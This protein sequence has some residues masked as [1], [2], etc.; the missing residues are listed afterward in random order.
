M[1][2]LETDVDVARYLDRIGHRGPTDVSLATLSA[3]QRAHMTAVPFENLDVASGVEVRT[4]LDW[5]L[6]KI[7]D[8][9]RGGWC[10]EV[11]GAFGALLTAMG[12]EVQLLGAAVLLSGPNTL[13]DHLMLEVT[14]D[15]PWLVDVG[16]GEGFT[17]PLALNGASPQPGGDGIYQF[18]PSPQGTTLAKLDD[19]VPVAQYRFKRVAHALSEFD[20]A[21]HRL[22]TDPA[23]PFVQKPFATRLLDGGPERVTLLRNRLRHL[24]DGEW[25]EQPV[26]LDQWAATLERWFGIGDVPLPA[27]SSDP[28]HSP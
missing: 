3:L 6:P 13:I 9:H 2:G 7:L 25:T 24:R 20:G 21:S 17:T 23:S 1:S 27:E 5:S 15:Q 16:F 10:F 19:D 28:E 18:L 11:N 14:L 22:Q 8:R 4:G 26:Q 12:F